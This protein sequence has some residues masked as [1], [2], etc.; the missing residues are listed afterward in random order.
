MD[1]NLQPELAVKLEQWS[2]QSGRPAGEVVEEAIAGYFA[3]IENVRKTLDS[4]Y[5]DIV[6]G[7]VEP[8]D[9]E[10]AVRLIKESGR[11][12]RCI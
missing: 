5:D 11:V 7:M 10:E 9:G 2:A 12:P 3:E 8:V 4:R 6:N 1:L